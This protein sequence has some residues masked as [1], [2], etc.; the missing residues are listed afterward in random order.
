M[1][2]GEH[3]EG[4]V[5]ALRAAMDVEL[6][7][8]ELVVTS[9]RIRMVSVRRQDGV[10]HVRVAR[11]FLSLGERCVQ[12]VVAFAAGRNEGR[13]AVNALIRELPR[14]EQRKDTRVA[15]PAGATHHLGDLLDEESR[16]A[17]GEVA[18]VPVTWGSRRRVRSRQ[19]SIRLGSYSPEREIIRVHPLLDHPAVPAWFVGFVLYH[20][21]LHHRLPP[22]VVSGRRRIHTPEFRMWER[23]HPRFE[24][25]QR[26]EIEHLPAILRRGRGRGAGK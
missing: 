12:P 2:S 20:E 14:P 11:E 13:V 24:E 25:A 23:R 6:D 10:H 16:R 9:N 5:A 15:R 17:F 18:R 26:W 21:L 8:P 22:V 19:R 4:V 7:R 3:F 1:H